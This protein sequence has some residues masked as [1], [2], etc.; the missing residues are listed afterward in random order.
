MELKPLIENAKFLFNVETKRFHNLLKQLLNFTDEH[1][2]SGIFENTLIEQKN[3]KV[4]LTA[5][6]SNASYQLR[7]KLTETGDTEFHPFLFNTRKITNMVSSLLDE[8]T[9]DISYHD[10]GSC[11]FKS[12]NA[13]FLFPVSSISEFV[14][15]DE[16]GGYNYINF[17]SNIFDIFKRCD[18]VMGAE[19]IFH[20]VNVIGNDKTLTIITSDGYG[21]YLRYDHQI[22]DGIKCNFK[23]TQGNIKRILSL[24][25]IRA[26][27]YVKGNKLR[28]TSPDYDCNLQ[29][30][31]QYREVGQ[32]KYNTDDFIINHKIIL[33][34]K[35]ILKLI[36]KIKGGQYL[37]FNLNS[38]NIVVD[39]LDDNGDTTKLVST[40]LLQQFNNNDV[41][42]FLVAKRLLKAVLS[43]IVGDVVIE[44]S[45]DIVRIKQG[46]YLF[47]IANG[48]KS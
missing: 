19:N 18:D 36:N 3:K 7:V 12:G 47:I 38:D 25:D 8:K 14:E 15:F 35:A 46:D 21:L 16:E 41:C 5:T 30:N 2:V 10:K 22:E 29:L 40:Y 31:N 32:E 27:F 48:L 39:I 9:V 43:K 4:Y 34:S 20:Y 42:D 13:Q 37:K 28:I 24:Y 33:D 17:P 23:I 11:L 1:C 45:D 6:D 26:E 44:I